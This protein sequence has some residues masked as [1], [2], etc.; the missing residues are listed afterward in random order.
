MA[1]LLG[2]EIQLLRDSVAVNAFVGGAQA[3]YTAPASKQVAITSVVMRCDAANAVTV[4]ASVKVEINP[5][6]GDIFTE[7]ILI[8]VLTVGDIW[9]FTA[10]ARGLVVPAGS[11]VDLVITNVATGTSQTFAV[12]VI[13]YFIY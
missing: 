12:D 11:Q 8:D 9:T 5:A 2:K 13:G 6:A 10:E 7:E 4:G 1:I 3:V